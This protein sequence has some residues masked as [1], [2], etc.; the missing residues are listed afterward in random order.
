MAAG[1]QTC[2][3][4][5]ANPKQ[6]LERLNDYMSKMITCLKCGRRVDQLTLS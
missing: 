3:T 1:L 6:E 4:A 2:W 5:L